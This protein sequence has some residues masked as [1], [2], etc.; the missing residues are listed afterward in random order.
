MSF[1]N[2]SFVA[3]VAAWALASVTARGAA[4]P[5]VTAVLTKSEAIVGEMVQLQIRATGDRDTEAPEDITVDGLEIHRTGTEQ[6]GELNN[7]NVSWSVIYTYILRADR[8]GT[9]KIPEQSVRVGKSSLKTQELTLR[10]TEGS[11]RSA[12]GS[13][14][15]GAN[16]EVASD[17][18]VAFLELV[19]PKRKGYVGEVLPVELR[20]AFRSGVLQRYEPPDVTAQGLTLRK[21]QQPQESTQMVDGAMYDV[22]T[23]KG[24]MAATYAGKIEVPALQTKAIV[25]LP[26]R[27]GT[28]PRQ[29]S[30]FDLFGMNDPFGDP[31]FNDPFSGLPEPR[32]I[33]LKSEPV[34]LEIQALPSNPPQSFTGAVG[35]FSVA[36]DANPKTVQ[37]GDPITVTI[38]VSGRGNFDRVNAPSFEDEGGWHK[39]PPSGKFKQND[40]VGISGTKSFEMVLST[41]ER[42]QSI[43][44]FLFT[45]FDP[46]KEGYVTAKTD[47]IPVQVNGGAPAPAAQPSAA[48]SKAATTAPAS[49]PSSDILQQLPDR[50][51]EHTFSQIYERREFWFAQIIPAVGIVGL[52]AWGW[53][54]RKAKDAKAREAAALRREMDSV[55]RVLRRDGTPPQEYIAHAA[56]AVRLKTAIAGGISPASVDAIIAADTFR[57]SDQQ[58]G[59]IQRIFE[60]SDELRYSGRAVNGEISPEWRREVLDVIES[61]HP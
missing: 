4:T 8:A 53:R 32:Q 30:P 38:T 47:A 58:R 21:A 26:R 52:L 3:F 41:T 11:G 29:R 13:Q 17:K 51:V 6:H 14:K 27:K 23:W 25:L 43:P 44:S 35:N 1:K 45:Y 56:R 39:Y 55:L 37:A 15:R 18:K 7:F 9:F 22:L 19:V 46:L 60:S 31:M 2:L 12:R 20:L 33:T 16:G 54:R 42:K 49:A 40:D 36:A 48:Q 61:L 10:V 57:A 59:V 50:G 24:A 28:T 34:T 5:A